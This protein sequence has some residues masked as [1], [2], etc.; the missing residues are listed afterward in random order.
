[1]AR[2]IDADALREKVLYHADTMN[3]AGNHEQ[4]KAFNYCL[5]M[6][7]DMPTADVVRCKDCK[8]YAGDG[9]YCANDIIVQFDHFYC[10][11]GERRQQ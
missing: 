3:H 2:Y 5:C 9:M 11:N 10:Y 4:A 6:I 8:W 1:M 7:D